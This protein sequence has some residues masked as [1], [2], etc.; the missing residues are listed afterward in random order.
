MTPRNEL[1]GAEKKTAVSLQRQSC[2]RTALAAQRLH[3]V[4]L[5]G[6]SPLMEA[7]T[8]A[9]IYRIINSQTQPSPKRLPVFR[10]AETPPQ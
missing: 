4:A 8:S 3:F 5:C 6:K 1:L 10:A 7:Q 9:G 2:E